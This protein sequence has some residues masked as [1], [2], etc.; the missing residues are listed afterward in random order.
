MLVKINH[1]EFK[2]DLS[3][4]KDKDLIQEI[5]HK[6][7]LLNNELADIEQM[8]NL[9]M[10]RICM[11]ALLDCLAQEQYN[12]PKK[13]KTKKVFCDFVLKYQ[14][15]CDYFEYVEPVT[16][17]YHVENKIA[18]S[19]LIPGFPPE[20][21]ISLETISIYDRQPVKEIIFSK[22]AK[23]ILQYIDQK[24]GSEFSKKKEEQHKLISLFYQMRNKAVHEM[25]TLGENWAAPDL[26]APKEPYYIC[27]NR[28]YESGGYFV[29]DDVIELKF[30]NV[31]IF[32][33]LKDCIA[34]Y[35]EECEKQKRIPFSNNKISRKNRLAWYDN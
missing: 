3:Y 1:G 13:D 8:T 31:F 12:Y 23:E 30:P 29:S 34:G 35:L 2:N 21:E 15:Q 4:D 18:D 17:Y 24:E 7:T 22:K 5:E 9:T 16:L 6:R 26:P 25:S 32:N 19:V 33:I 28:M 10:Q 14:K 11:F 20:K 27:V